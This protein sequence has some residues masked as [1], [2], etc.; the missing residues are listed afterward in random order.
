MDLTKHL[1]ILMKIYFVKLS[2][3]MEPPTQYIIWY[4]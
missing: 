3:K 1:I 4:I 2:W